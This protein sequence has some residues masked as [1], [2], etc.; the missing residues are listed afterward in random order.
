MVGPSGS[1]ESS[2]LRLLNRLDESTSGRVFL[3][4]RL[5]HSLPPELLQNIAVVETLVTEGGG[6]TTIAARARGILRKVA[7]SARKAL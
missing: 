6:M 7:N 1:G 3:E 5:R 4:P 2:C